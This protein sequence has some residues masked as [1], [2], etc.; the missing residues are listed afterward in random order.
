MR[1][2]FEF[3]SEATEESIVAWLNDLLPHLPD[4]TTA[5]VERPPLLLGVE[6][7]TPLYMGKHITV[8]RAKDKPMIDG[9]LDAVYKRANSQY[10]RTVIVDGRAHDVDAYEVVTLS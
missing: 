1:L 8:N 4:G 6:E 7:L 10:G 5:W 3:E 9:T 2:I